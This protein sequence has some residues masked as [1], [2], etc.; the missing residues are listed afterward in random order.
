MLL[1]TATV[2]VLICLIC[3]QAAG[4]DKPKEN[5]PEPE[6][7]GARL[8]WKD[9]PKNIWSDQKAIWS[10]PFHINRDKCQMVDSVWRRDRG[11]DCHRQKIQSTSAQLEYA[12]QC[13][14]MGVTLGRR[15][16]N[17]STNGAVLRLR[18]ANGQSTRPRYRPHW[19]RSSCRC[20]DH[21][22]Y[23]E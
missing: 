18:Q 4:Q 23:L 6:A 13:K 3:N 11:I 7:H 17:L 2:F 10:S 16:F 9:L 19:H 12:A 14:Q 1:R 8:Q 20:G 15:L 5:P 22:Q 21:G